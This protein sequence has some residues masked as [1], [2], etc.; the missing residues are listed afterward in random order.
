MSRGRGGWH[1]GDMVA[2]ALLAALWGALCYVTVVAWRIYNRSL[3]VVAGRRIEYCR[4]LYLFPAQIFGLVGGLFLVA[5][6][7]ALVALRAPGEVPFIVLVMAIGAGC[8]WLARIMIRRGS[9]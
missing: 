6:V 1:L 8:V 4:S 9:L 3:G 5:S 2:F 7:V